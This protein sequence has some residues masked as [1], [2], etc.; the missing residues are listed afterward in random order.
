M[1]GPQGSL[2]LFVGVLADQLGAPLPGLPM[3]LAAG[4][5]AGAVILVV[6]FYL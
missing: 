2:V 1:T 5:L 3:L 6:L 4:A